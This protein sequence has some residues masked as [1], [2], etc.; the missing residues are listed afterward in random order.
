MTSKVPDRSLISGMDRR[1][2]GAILSLAAA[3]VAGMVAAPSA[4]ALTYK[5]LHTFTGFP[6]NGSDSYAVV[7]LVAACGRVQAP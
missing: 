2:A 7:T 5:I 4:Q 3:L 6:Y 1:A